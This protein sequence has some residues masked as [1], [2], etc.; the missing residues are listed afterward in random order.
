LGDFIVNYDERGEVVL[1]E[2]AKI[3]GIIEAKM[4]SNLSQGTKNAKNYNQASRNICC[5]SYVTRNSP[6]CEIFF[7]VVAPEET[8]KKNEIENQIKQENVLNQIK[9][10]FQ[11]SAEE[12]CSEIQEQAEKCKILTISYKEWINEI[13]DYEV[14]K[15]LDE[16][17][18]K[19]ISYNKIKP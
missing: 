10:R 14:K 17:Y 11:H 12:Y 16:F 19:C 7:V 6:N 5:L 4:G 1:N 8:I 13:K 15:I 2:S 9:A 18:G 3:L